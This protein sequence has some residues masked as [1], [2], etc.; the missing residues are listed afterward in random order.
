MNKSAI[1]GSLKR[2]WVG[3]IA[4][5]VGVLLG[6]TM[7]AAP[8]YSGDM[9]DPY[10]QGVGYRS[11]CYQ[12]GCYQCGCS[13]CGCSRCGCCGPIGYRRSHV[14]ERHWVEREYYE[15]RYPVGGHRYYGGYADSYGG[16]YGRYPGF[17]YGGMRAGPYSAS[18]DYDEPPRP[19][20]AVYGVRSP[21]YYDGYGE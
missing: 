11:G 5:I 9:Y 21:Y 1:V 3:C 15:R 14:T 4:T 18:Y 20:A 8:A 17:G 2:P 13:Q 6:E 19:P 7:I 16:Q 10:Y 12:C